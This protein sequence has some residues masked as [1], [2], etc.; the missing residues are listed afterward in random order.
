[1]QSN[2]SEYSHK[3]Q[4][5]DKTSRQWEDYNDGWEER[6]EPY[7]HIAQDSYQKY[8]GDGQSSTERTGR[9]R[10]YSDSPK[11]LYSKDAMNRD[12]GRKSSARRRTSSPV[13]GTCEK[14]R[15]RCTED[16][17]DY[18]YRREP[19]DETDRQSPD[20]FSSAHVT[21]DFK[22][23]L[24]EKEDIRYRKTP[25]DSKHRYRHKEFTYRQ[26]PD[27][28]RQSSGYYKGRDG[29]E[30]SQDV[31]QERTQSQDSSTKSFTNPRERAD[32][33]AADH[34]DYRQRFPL[35]EPSG[36]SFERAVSSQSAAVPEQKKSAMG[37]QRFLDV[38]NKGVN[39]TVLNKIVAQ[40]TTE[41]SDPPRSPTPVKNTN[42]PWSPG[43]VG[44]Q[45]GSHQNTSHWS[46]CERSQR[47]TSPK[48]HHRSF[49][50]EGR[51][52][53]DEKCL[54]RADGE[55]SYF[56]S[57]S[58]PVSPSLLG[59]VTLTPE[60]EHKHRQMQDVLQAIGI[61]L[62]SEELGQMSHR[63]HE[64]LYGK[65]DYDVGRHRRGSRE[66]DTRPAFSPRPLS[67][68]SSSSRS[69]FS[70]V[71]REYHQKK[72][73]FSAQR[74][75]TEVQQIQVHES[76]GYGRNSSSGTSQESQKCESYSQESTAACPSFSHNS[77]YTLSTSSPTPVM[78]NYSPVNRSPLMP[79][80]ALPPALPPPNL[81]HLGPRFF[82]PNLPPFLP[83]PLAP[84]LNI[85]PALLAQTRNL[86]NPSNPP[87]FNLPGN[88]PTQYMNTT[89]KSKTLSRPRCLQVIE[90]KQPG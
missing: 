66:R 90:T 28:C 8:G 39:V 36:Q 76:V 33:P 31:S 55:Q 2:R 6:R 49:S 64:R 79:Y 71:N 70:L 23:T 32:G 53:S 19:E 82:M 57:N 86:I 68:S 83:Y 9:S 5:N 44:G 52:P 58:R 34:K 88:T 73:L 89:Q 21:K 22:H 42:R 85:F 35:N 63:I 10:E 60:E 54:Q 87:F 15:R 48:P 56:S 43:Y 26:Q 24:P 81:P 3:R 77:S 29:Q 14:K 75:E 18:M 12:W 78:P 40:T 27:D 47:L 65:K 74:D 17:D 25:Q 69:S 37:F 4:Y 45:Q 38:L 1:M 61:D 11:M 7:R 50:P 84:P 51:A 72:D 20:S 46:K 62:G 16:K 13:W 59:K 80:P 67:R 30:R 41:V